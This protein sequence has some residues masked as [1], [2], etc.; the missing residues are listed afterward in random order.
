MKHIAFAFLLFSC[1]LSSYTAPAQDKLFDLADKVVELFS[2]EIPLDSGQYPVKWVV[3]PVVAYAPET[4]WQFGVGGKVLFRPRSVGKVERTSF[5]SFAVRYTLNNQ[6][7]TSPEYTIFLR[8]EKYIHRGE[9]TYTKFPRLYFGIGN[10]TPVN[11]REAFSYN[12]ISFEHLLYRN[13]FNKLYTGIGFRVANNFNIEIEEDGLLQSG[14]PV[15]VLTNQAVGLD[16][17]I[18]FDSRNN[19]LSTTHGVLAEF[20]QRFHK[21]W[22]GSDFDYAVG[23]LDVRAYWQPSANRRDIIAWQ[24]YGYFSDGETP[25]TELAGLGGDMIMRGYYDGR[26]LDNHLL[27]TQVEYRFTIWRELGG[28]AFAGIGDV[29]NRFLNF[30]FPD[31]KH[32]LGAGL[33]YALIPEENLNIRLDFAAGKET[34]NFYIN[35]SESF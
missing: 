23:E 4:S 13:V 11:N 31:I 6:L 5:V 17:G 14:Q 21:K 20:R 2:G 26:Y 25:F 29:T 24:L 19:A 34:T 15:G 1:L 35:I 9:L 18:M 12:T 10:N 30:N 8:N 27:A 7:T 33:R 16:L 32:S 22:L 3:A 28:V